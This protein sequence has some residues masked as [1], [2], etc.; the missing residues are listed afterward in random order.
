MFTLNEIQFQQM[1][2]E[3]DAIPVIEFGVIMNWIA[4]KPTRLLALPQEEEN[5]ITLASD[6]FQLITAIINIIR[7]YNTSEGCCCIHWM[8]T[9]QIFNSVSYP[10]LKIVADDERLEFILNYLKHRKALEKQK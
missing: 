10:V 1:S 5:V 7:G 8:V 4:N 6:Q 9:D 3:L 2:K